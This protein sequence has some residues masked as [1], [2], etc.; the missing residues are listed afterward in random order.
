MIGGFILTGDTEGFISAE[1]PPFSWGRTCGRRTLFPGLIT[2]GCCLN[3]AVI[4]W[5]LRRTTVC[6]FRE[7]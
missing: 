6:L 4:R 5:A 2:N 1:L 3:L 7:R